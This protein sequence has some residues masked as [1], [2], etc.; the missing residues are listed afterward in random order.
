MPSEH[1]LPVRATL[2]RIGQASNS[3]PRYQRGSAVKQNCTEIRRE[4]C[5]E[6]IVLLPQGLRR[7]N[8]QRWPGDRGRLPMRSYG[9]CRFG[10]IARLALG[11]LSQ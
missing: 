7:L 2:G 1:D 10:V 4:D 9:P 5:H 3:G 6:W 11:R 8:L